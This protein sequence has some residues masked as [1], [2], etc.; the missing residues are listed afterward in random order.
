MRSIMTRYAPASAIFT[1][2]SL[3]NSAVTFST[4]KPLIF[5]TSAGGKVFSM[6]KMIPIFFTVT[7]DSFYEPQRKY[8]PAIFC[9]QGQSCAV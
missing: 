3:T 6:P 1:P 4:F 2:P 5:S 8:L 9:H 7:S